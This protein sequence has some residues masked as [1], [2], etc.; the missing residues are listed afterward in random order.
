MYFTEIP[1]A[2]P[3]NGRA[4][5]RAYSYIRLRRDVPVRPV[6]TGA[7]ANGRIL[8]YGCM[9]TIIR[10]YLDNCGE[11]LSVTFRIK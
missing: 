3:G 4:P 5:G 6:E 7:H 2:V 1:P 10:L 11:P 8:G 9:F